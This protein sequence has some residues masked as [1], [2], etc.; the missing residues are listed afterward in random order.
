V[1]VIVVMDVMFLS[2]IDSDFTFDSPVFFKNL[3]AFFVV[4]LL[5]WQPTLCDG[6][7]L[8]RPFGRNTKE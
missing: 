1:I 8:D 3:I 4:D 5:S 7:S 6:M 2:M